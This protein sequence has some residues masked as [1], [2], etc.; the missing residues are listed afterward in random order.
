MPQKIPVPTP[1]TAAQFVLID[2]HQAAIQVILDGSK[3]VLTESQTKAS[4][5][6]GTV[7][8]D[9]IKDVNSLIVVAK[10][11][12]VPVAVVIADFESELLYN[13]SLTKRAAIA[14]SQTAMLNTLLGVGENNTMNDVNLIVNNARL[15]AGADKDLAD[16]VKTLQDKYFTK[17]APKKATGYFIVALGIMMI[18]GVKTRKKFVNTGNTVLTILKLDG[19]ISLLIRVNPGMGVNIPLRWTNI[20]VT[21]LSATESGSFD[22]FLA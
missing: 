22:L 2:T 1:I 3:I 11:Y 6:V 13:A 9:Q 12:A 10:P 8:S 17:A 4:L 20:V 19:N 18:G 5:F 14:K 7:R 16:D 15:L 21:N